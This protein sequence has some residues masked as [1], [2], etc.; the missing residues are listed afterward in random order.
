MAI[1]MAEPIA[2]VT[3]KMDM[4]KA[5]MEAGALEYAY[6]KP[7]MDAKISDRAMSTYAGTCHPMCTLFG[8]FLNSGLH[9]RGWS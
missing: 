1:P 5:F 6:S 9:F 2:F 8:V 7:V 4:M 3:K